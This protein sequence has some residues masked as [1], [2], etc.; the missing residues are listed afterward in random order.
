MIEDRDPGKDSAGILLG[1]WLALVISLLLLLTGREQDLLPSQ[2]RLIL[3][4]VWPAVVLIF[5]FWRHPAVVIAYS[6]AGGFYLRWAEFFPGGGSDVLPATTE[7]LKT[8]LSGGN[9]YVH[10]YTSTD[11]PGGLAPYPPANF[12][13]HLPGYL[14]A[15]H[16]GVRF[17]QIFLAIVVMALLVCLSRRVSWGVGLPVLALY[18][19]LPNLVTIS[20]DAG[21]D[22]GAGAMT[23]LAVIAL[24]FAWS[25]GF[26]RNAVLLAG[27]AAAVAVCTKQFALFPLL[28]LFMY[29]FRRG[30]ASAFGQYLAAFIIS[31]GILVIPFLFFGPGRFVHSLV[32][33]ANSHPDIY[34]WNIWVLLQDLNLPVLE[35][36]QAAAL[37]MAAT[38]A[39]AVP[40]LLAP[41][42]RLSSAVT[43]GILFVLVPLLFSRWTAY[44]YYAF[45]A[46]LLL[47]VPLLAAWE[48]RL[49]E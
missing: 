13:I 15:G 8:L 43:A 27:L 40:A 21:N 49:G 2:A 20:V 39:A 42:R 16:T 36:D 37:S 25:S 34:G 24:A 35:R 38:L 23:L 47:S 22:T 28:P 3:L 12:I 5:A 14:L 48:H 30:G 31:M 44:S 17:T 33:V 18:S 41:C 7:W 32:V 6:L 4:L 19:G 11:P 9:P 45:L 46:P 10:Y 26:K 1:G 29:V